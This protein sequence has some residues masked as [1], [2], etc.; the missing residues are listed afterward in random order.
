MYISGV[1]CALTFCRF[2]AVQVGVHLLFIVGNKYSLQY[3]F[4]VK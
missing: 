2:P 4:S 1:F 3:I